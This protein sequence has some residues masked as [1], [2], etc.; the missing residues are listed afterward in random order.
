M[1]SESLPITPARFAAALEDL[2]LGSLRLKSLELRN[3]LAH[4]AYSNAQL[5]PFA[6][7]LR[8]SSSAPDAAVENVDPDPDCADAIRENEIV[9]ARMRERLL[10]VRAEVERR[11]A[12]WR[13]F[14]E[15]DADEG[16]E[17]QEQPY[18]NGRADGGEGNEAAAAAATATSRGGGGGASNPWTDG[19]FQTGVIRNGEVHMDEVSGQR[20]AGSAGRASTTSSTVGTTTAPPAAGAPA[21]AAAPEAS[22]DTGART[23]G[24][25]LTDEDL[26]R[27]LEARLAEDEVDEEDGGLHL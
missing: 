5:R 17:A 18:T 21:A 24:G 4:L 10:L 19:T 8:P 7:G 3:S 6:E 25:R 1:S 16:E 12:S 2:S 14:G 22:T 11:G 27:L 20:E 23:G 13:E 9:M 26:R 15:G